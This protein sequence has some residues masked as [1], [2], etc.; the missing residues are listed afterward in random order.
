MGERR[1]DPPLSC[2]GQR[3]ARP[4][5]AKKCPPGRCAEP[6]PRG[7]LGAPISV[8][9]M[10]LRGLVRVAWPSRCGDVVHNLAELRRWIWRDGHTA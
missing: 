1:D 3:E 5:G 2:K 6:Q 8:R 7:M 10:M 4:E 9:R